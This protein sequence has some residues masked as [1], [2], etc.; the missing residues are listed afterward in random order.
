MTEA[1]GEFMPIYYSTSYDGY[2]VGYMFD[3]LFSND[4]AGNYIPHVAKEWEIQKI[5]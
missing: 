2:V 5:T 1:K 3:A 4:E